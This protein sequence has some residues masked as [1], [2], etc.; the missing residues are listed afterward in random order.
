MR[1][2]TALHV[3][4]FL[5]L[6]AGVA[7]ADRGDRFVQRDGD[8]D[9]V[10]TLHEYQ[11]TGGH[12]GNFRALDLNG[13]G[14]LTEGEFVGRAGVSEQSAY[15]A[16]KVHPRNP[17][18]LVKDRVR[19]AIARRAGQSRKVGTFDARDWNGDGVLTRAEYGDART[20]RSV[21]RNRDGRI[22]WQEFHRAG[23]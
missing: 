1:L 8:G 11:S 15:E 3:G 4:T 18:V 20:F 9:G 21:D 5:A 19:G 12:P 23:R 14:V 7:S 16:V 10:L 13:D 6:S 2:R 17:D 22:T